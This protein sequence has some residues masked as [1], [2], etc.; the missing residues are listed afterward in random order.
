MDASYYRSLLRP[1]FAGRKV[2]ICGGPL[3]AATTT[4]A[5][6]RDLGAQ[7][8]FVLAAG[9]GTGPVPGED[10]AGRHV[11]QVHAADIVDEI[12]ATERA[13]ASIPPDAMAA[14]DAWDPAREAIVLGSFFA[15]GKELLGRR[16][17]G[18]REAE[19]VALED[20]VVIDV[21]WDEAGVQRAP[22][23]V[24]PPDRDA[25]LGAARRLDRGSGTAWAGDASEGFNGGARMLRWVRSG[26]D[27]D[28]AVA[29]LAAHCHRVR[30]D[31]LSR[32][33]P[34]FD[35]RCCLP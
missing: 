4:V 34:L 32:G 1:V 6:L 14:L 29:F 18:A 27:V 22:S 13:L 28:E 16:L 25:L 10:E 26:D 9:V 2:L 12:R 24:V 7:R 35:P 19:W 3:A 31:A 33:R 21:F 30:G 15:E 17:F 11:L 8:P 5:A 20:K 23:E